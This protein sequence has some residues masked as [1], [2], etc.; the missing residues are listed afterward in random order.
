MPA[1]SILIRTI[2]RQVA[3]KD[4]L[5]SLTAQQFRDFE[6]IVAED[7]PATL[8][9]FLAGYNNLTIRYEAL[10]TRKGRST[11][12]NRALSMAQGEYCIFLDEDDVFYPT[13]LQELIKAAS[14]SYHK[15]VYSWSEER[16]AERAADGSITQ[17]G[18]FKRYRRETFS[19][20]HLLAGN[21]LP[22]NAVLF[23]RSLFERAGGFDEDIDCLEDWLLWLRY[24]AI[25]PE[26]QCVPQITAVYYTPLNRN[27]R[28]KAF[29]AWHEI[30]H[31]R[32]RSINP[33]LSVATLQRDLQLHFSIAVFLRKL[34]YF[35]TG[36]I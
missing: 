18:K 20:L 1:I 2:G 28:R 7:G 11:A 10:G 17:S 25:E 23:H 24:A 4:A 19:L 30:V 35:L 29:R 13:H 32:M 31:K 22:I 14:A 12:G 27:E 26:W 8:D 21:Y 33:I 6:V 16:R 5:D 36:Y 15:V 34:Y 9:S 3:L